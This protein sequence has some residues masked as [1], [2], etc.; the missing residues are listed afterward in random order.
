[1]K[2]KKEKSCKDC[3]CYGACKMH[4]RHKCELTYDTQREINNAMR[5]A[6]KNSHICE[7]FKDSSKFMELP[8][9]LK[10]GDRVYFIYEDKGKYEVYNPSIV[11]AVMKEGFF[12]F[13]D[14]RCTEKDEFDAYRDDFNYYSEI[15]KI[16]FYT[17]KEAQKAVD[18]K[19]KKEKR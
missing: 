11:S 14:I 7:H 5:Q 2:I 19:N 9:N 16:C 17:K 6:Q 12:T 13:G 15:G 10:K 3:M 8:T 18:K 4:Y 1:M